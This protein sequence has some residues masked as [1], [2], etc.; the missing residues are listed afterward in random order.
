MCAL[1][2][3][4]WLKSKRSIQQNQ[5]VEIMDSETDS[6]ENEGLDPE[7]REIVLGAWR[8]ML[9]ACKD[10]LRT[11]VPIFG[12]QGGKLIHDRT[13]ILFQIANKHFLITASHDLAQ[14]ASQK[15]PL[16]LAPDVPGLP[17]IPIGAR[18]LGT[19]SN[20]IDIAVFELW[21]SV[22]EKMVP[23]RKFLRMSD[24]DHQAKNEEGLYVAMGYP[25]QFTRPDDKLNRIHI[26]ILQ[27]L[28]YLYSG[29]APTEPEYPYNPDVHL[30][31]RHVADGHNTEGIPLSSPRISGMSGCGIWRLTKLKPAWATSWKLEDRKLVAI[32]A[33]CWHGRY[34]KGTWIKYALQLIAKTYPDLRRAMRL[35][36]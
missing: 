10:D 7:K 5:G 27:Y 1:G 21:D 11:T 29:D 16:F 2:E 23:G 12:S 35:Y 4:L 19:E 6:L 22:V 14:I 32:Q 20:V 15:V 31:L 3:C 34:L 28:A 33:K 9:E 24:L 30:L 18:M 36:V 13:G 8:S 25:H 17:A 26:G